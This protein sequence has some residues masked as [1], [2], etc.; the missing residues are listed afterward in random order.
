MF[1]VELL[2]SNMKPEAETPKKK[3]SVKRTLIIVIVGILVTGGFFLYTNFNRLLSRALIK[4]FES[5]IISDVYELKFENLW[6][7]VFEGSI[8]VNNVTLVPRKTPLKNYPY[9]NSYFKL[10]TEKLTLTNV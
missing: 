1:K 8:R 5:S 4:N 7:N 10:K 2:S 3:R 9:I 6:V